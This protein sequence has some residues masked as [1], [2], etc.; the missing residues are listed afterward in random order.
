MRTL[1]TDSTI[2]FLPMLTQFLSLSE[3]SLT[4]LFIVILILKISYIASNGLELIGDE[5]YYWDWSRQPDWCYY[6]KPP[7]VAWIIAVAT[8][9]GGSSV[10]SV[11][12]PAA[13]LNTLTLVYLYKTTS[14]VYSPKAGCLALLILIAMPFNVL[15]GFIMTIDAPLCC[16]W[17]MSLYYLEQ[18]LFK[19]R[20]KAW[21]WAGCATGAAVL[22]KQVA[23]LLPLMVL[24]Y[25]ALEQN[26]RQLL[27]SRRFLSYLV[28]V[29]LS[30]IPILAWNAEHDWVM[31]EHSKHHLTQEVLNLSA[32]AGQAASFIG[33]Q[34]LLVSPLLC[35]LVISDSAKRLRHFKQLNAAEQFLTLTG[36]VLLA[37]IFLLNLGQKTQGNWA[38]PFYFSAIILTSG[39]YSQL[40]TL[41]NSLANGIKLGL[42]L[43]LITYALPLLISAFNLTN[44]PLDPTSRFKYWRQLATQ[45]D[46]Y[47][48]Q[49]GRD[50]F[51]ITLGHR[52]MTSE[53]AFYLPEQPQVYRYETTGQIASQYELWPGP[54][55]PIDHSAYLIVEHKYIPLPKAVTNAFEHIQTL[56]QIE[57]SIDPSNPYHVLLAQGLKQWPVLS[58]PE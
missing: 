57:N 12:I 44:S 45:V 15:L 27:L 37:S 49:H 51:I 13:L 39:S 4:W 46:S 9:L 19:K 26:R 55:N 56:G 20:D 34:L 5:S 43:V 42:G 38:V 40:K 8:T 54:N 17:A 3:R 52:F 41:P 35:V 1:Q 16:F 18:A 58:R 33:Y 50:A 25:L 47:R 36:P 23:L 28:P 30:L 2:C 32:R 7:M 11:R 6:S 21:L 14:A 48:Q 29:L 22:S 53:L 10:E 24:I 31:Y